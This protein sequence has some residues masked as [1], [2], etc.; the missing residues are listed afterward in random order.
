MGIAELTTKIESLSAEDYNMV[1]M[2]VN[3]LSEK[4]EIN[5]LK[6]LSENELVEELSASI[7]KSDPGATGH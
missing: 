1:I 5:G 7:R 4:S 3:R 2:L 6:R